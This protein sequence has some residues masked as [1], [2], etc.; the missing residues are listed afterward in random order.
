GVFARVLVSIA[1]LWVGGSTPSHA[2]SPLPPPRDHEVRS[3][4]G[5]CA[6]R[7]EVGASRIVVSRPAGG[8][9]ETLWTFRG[10]CDFDAL[11][12]DC[13]TL[14]VIYGG[15]NLLYLDDRDPSTAVIR[16]YDYAREVR[17]ITLGELYPDLTVLARTVR[18][19]CGMSRLAEPTTIC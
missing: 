11:A 19:G 13:R 14:V 5:R 1:A 9:T 8:R 3:P 4:S 10:Y 15:A 17:K 12:D 18:T 7:A 2:D 6:A 16:F